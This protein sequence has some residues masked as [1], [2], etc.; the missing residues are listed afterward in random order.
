MYKQSF[1]EKRHQGSKT[2]RP[3]HRFPLDEFLPVA[4]SL[5][6]NPHAARPPL[7]T[8]SLSVNISLQYNYNHFL[9]YCAPCSRKIGYFLF[10]SVGLYK[11]GS[12]NRSNSNHTSM[13][14]QSRT[15]LE[16]FFL[17]R[18]L[19]RFSLVKFGWTTTKDISVH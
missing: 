4:C 19:P 12:C 15:T 7:R 17:S 10:S 9:L 18:K 8:V 6:L 11:V 5:G 3:G 2:A 16:T 14:N 13:T 1:L